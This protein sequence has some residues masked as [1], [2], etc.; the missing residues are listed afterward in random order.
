MADTTTVQEQ[1][2][3]E[4]P[5]IEAYKIGLLKLAQDTA[6]SPVDVP[7]AKVAGMTDQQ[8]EAIKMAGKGVGSYEPYITSAGGAYTKAAEGY[9]G[10]PQYGT[11]AMGI[12]SLGG[13]NATEAAQGYGQ[14][15]T[16]LAISGAQAYDP[17]SVA[18]YMNPYQQGVTQNAIAEMN[19]QAQIQQAN[20]ASGAAKAGAFGG[21]RFGVQEA[22]LGRNLA[23]VQSKKIFEDYYNNYAQAQK[24]SMD[25]FQQQQLRA[26]NAGTTALGAGQNISN[27]N[28]AAGQLGANTAVSAGNLQNTS[29]QGIESLG[30]DTAA[31]GQQL[32]GLQQ[33]DTS[34]LYNVGLKQQDFAQKELDTEYK[35]K[36]TAAYEPFQRVSF[37]SDIYKGAPSSQQTIS[38]STAPSPSLVSQAAGVGTAG[39][40]AY[41]LSKP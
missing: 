29:A 28:I 26:Q 40:A 20:T 24:S 27:S 10:L 2:V 32:S 11:E 3:R 8:T 34:F 33:G 18:D 37:L 6:A 23:D 30:K 21:S 15:G 14:L 7:Q 17:N 9:G 25:A 5:D 36:A 39:L 1:I 4:A 12:A 13:Q 35:N 22:E 38:Q 41:N 16:Q 31:L 19:R